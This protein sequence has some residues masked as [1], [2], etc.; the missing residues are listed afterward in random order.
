M[1]GKHQRRLSHQAI[2]SGTPKLLQPQ[3]EVVQAINAP[4]P[5][6]AI[7]QHRTQ[8]VPESLSQFVRGC[9]VSSTSFCSSVVL[10]VVVVVTTST[11]LR[12]A[13]LSHV[14]VSGLSFPFALI[15]ISV[16]AITTP[17]SRGNDPSTSNQSSGLDRIQQFVGRPLHC[18]STWLLLKETTSVATTAVFIIIIIIII[19]TTTTTTTTNITHIVGKR[20]YLKVP[21]DKAAV[22]AAVRHQ[23]LPLWRC[24]VWRR[25]HDVRHDLHLG[26]ACRKLRQ[27]RCQQRTV[28]VV[29][30]VE[31][32]D[33]V[34]LALALP[35]ALKLRSAL[36][37]P[38]ARQHPLHNHRHQQPLDARPEQQQQCENQQQKKNKKGGGGELSHCDDNLVMCV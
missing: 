17:Q 15:D 21:C 36:L 29:G 3:L 33:L 5:L 19:A 30:L 13:S 7:V 6:A 32:E 1:R 28:W 4:V 2:L 38:L 14:R 22:L 26:I 31:V 24:A 25:P 37:Q 10:V 9:D 20:A 27:A 23:P 8:I 35:L 12:L 18:R 11:L 34:R 16:T